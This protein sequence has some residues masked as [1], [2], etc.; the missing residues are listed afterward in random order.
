[1]GAWRV[2]KFGWKVD[3]RAYDLWDRKKSK[4]KMED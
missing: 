2:R 3:Q 1:M 4:R